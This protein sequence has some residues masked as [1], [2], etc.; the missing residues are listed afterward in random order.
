MNISE[1]MLC[2]EG[3]WT[4]VPNLPVFINEEE[5][6]AV[7]QA[8]ESRTTINKRVED[9]LEEISDA[10]D[11]N[12][13]VLR[14]LSSYSGTAGLEDFYENSDASD[15]SFPPWLYN[16]IFKVMM[17]M[18]ENPDSILFHNAG[19]GKAI[20]LLP[21]E[22]KERINKGLTKIAIVNEVE[23]TSTKI[24]RILYPGVPC[25]FKDENVVIRDS[26]QGIA[27]FN[28][29]IG[30]SYDVIISHSPSAVEI[31]E[32]SKALNEG[33]FLITMVEPDLTESVAHE[34]RR[35]IINKL[36]VIG[37][38]R[39]S[40]FS[41]IECSGLDYGYDIMVFR[42]P[43][44]VDR[45]FSTIVKNM[46][47]HYVSCIEDIKDDQL[48]KK[49]KTVEEICASGEM[50]KQ[51]CQLSQQ[52]EV[53]EVHMALYLK[54]I[55]IR[56]KM[57]ECWCQPHGMEMQVRT[58]YKKRSFDILLGIVKQQFREVMSKDGMVASDVNALLS[59]KT[60]NSRIYSNIVVRIND[61]LKNEAGDLK[62]TD[63]VKSKPIWLFTTNSYDGKPK[64]SGSYNIIFDLIREFDGHYDYSLLESTSELFVYKNKWFITHKYGHGDN[65]IYFKPSIGLYY[66]PIGKIDFLTEAHTFKTYLF[67][68]Q[69]QKEIT[70]KD[71]IVYLGN[72][73]VGIGSVIIHEGLILKKLSNDTK[74]L[75]SQAFDLAA[76]TYGIDVA[77]RVVQ[78]SMQY[79][80]ESIYQEA[81]NS[82]DDLSLGDAEN[83]LFGI[84]RFALKDASDKDVLSL[85]EMLQDV[86]YSG[87]SSRYL[88]V[89]DLA[90]NDNE[91]ELLIGRITFIDHLI[92][93]RNLINNNIDTEDN[94]ILLKQHYEAFCEQHQVARIAEDKIIIK[95]F[96]HPENENKSD[97]RWFIIRSFDKAYH[98]GRGLF[99][100]SLPY[101]LNEVV[102]TPLE[103]LN[104]VCSK[105]DYRV[106][107]D[108]KHLLK[109]GAKYNYTGRYPTAIIDFEDRKE[110]IRQCTETGEWVVDVDNIFRGEYLIKTEKFVFGNIG[111]KLSK[112]KEFETWC[113]SKNI[114]TDNISLDLIISELQNK[115][116]SIPTIPEQII[117]FDPHMHIVDFKKV[118]F[119]FIQAAYNGASIIE[120]DFKIDKTEN[121]GVGR[122]KYYGKQFDAEIPG[123]A[124]KS[125]PV[126]RNMLIRWFNHEPE[127][128]AERD[129]R[130]KVVNTKHGKAKMI[131]DVEL[132]S[133]RN[134]FLRAKFND[135][136]R[137][138]LDEKSRQELYDKYNE[139]Y[140]IYV[141]KFSEEKLGVKGM[142]TIFNGKP[143]AM[144][145]FQNRFAAR[146][147][148]M[149]R[150]YGNH[151]VGSGKTISALAAGWIAKQ[152]GLINKAMYV[153]LLKNLSQWEQH[154]KEL[155]PTATCLVVTNANK[156]MA[157]CDIAVNDYDFIII[158]DSTWSECI[159][160]SSQFK[161]DV[162]K[163]E[164][165][166]YFQVK[167][168]L[169]VL[170]AKNYES[171][172][173]IKPQL[174]S[175]TKYINKELNRIS[176]LLERSKND[177]IE[178][179]FDKMGVD[180]L[181]V[182]EADVYKNVDTGMDSYLQK[183][184][185]IRKVS[186]GIATTMRLASQFIQMQYNY[187]NR[188]DMTGT[189]VSNSATEIYQT[190]NSITPDLLKDAGILT[191][192]D[193]I[194]S[195]GRVEPKEVVNTQNQIETKPTFTGMRNVNQIKRLINACFDVLTQ[196]T[197]NDIKR[198]QGDPI[199]TA[200]YDNVIYPSTPE[201]ILMNHYSQ[202]QVTVMKELAKLPPESKAI[203]TRK[204]N[205]V[206]KQLKQLRS[207][208]EAKLKY[209]IDTNEIQAM[210]LEINELD[211]VRRLLS[212]NGGVLY[213]QIRS[214]IVHTKLYN[215]FIDDSWREHSKIKKVVERAVKSYLYNDFDE[216]INIDGLDFYVKD[217]K[218]RAVKNGQ[219][220]LLD[221]MSRSDID[222]FNARDEYIAAIKAALPDEDGVNKEKLFAS[223]D[224]TSSEPLDMRRVKKILLEYFDTPNKNYEQA[225]KYFEQYNGED[226]FFELTAVVDKKNKKPK[227]I[228]YRDIV[229]YLYNLGFIRFVFGSTDSMGIGMNLQR[230]TTN[231]H[232]ID[233]PFRPRDWEQRIGR[234]LRQGNYNSE[235]WIHSYSSEGGSEV[236][237]LQLLRIKE[238]F[239]QQIFDLKSL[240]D[241]TAE[242][243]I[244][245][246]MTG[247][248]E[249]QS[250]FLSQLDTM[251]HDTNDKRIQSF[252]DQ[253]KELESLLNRRIMYHAVIDNHIR[254]KARLQEQISTIE[255]NTEMYVWLSFDVLPEIEKKEAEQDRLDEEYAERVRAIKNSEEY[256]S[257]IKHIEERHQ[258]VIDLIT[259]PARKSRAVH[260]MEQKIY[261]LKASFIPEPPLVGDFDFE[262]KTSLPYRFDWARSFNNEIC[263]LLFDCYVSREVSGY[264]RG[265]Y[266]T[267][268]EQTFNYEL[269]EKK[270]FTP[271]IAKRL[272]RSRV[273]SFEKGDTYT[274]G[275]LS[276]IIRQKISLIGRV[277]DSEVMGCENFEK[278]IANVDYLET[279]KKAEY[280]LDAVNPDNLESLIN[281]KSKEVAENQDAY[282]DFIEKQEQI[283][284]FA[285]YTVEKL[286]GFDSIEQ[287]M[288]EISGFV[289]LKK[290]YESDA[291]GEL[292][293][294]SSYLDE[295]ILL[296]AEYI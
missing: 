179:S 244:T 266:V 14:V 126:R 28:K 169:E 206:K 282:Y 72:D 174:K 277:M 134:V 147:L 84:A 53:D 100:D 78:F 63:I 29:I 194:A 49:L 243:S 233:M 195:H 203:I 92:E 110:F 246:L 22:I 58:L 262:F 168:Y 190:L 119:P 293:T 77:N 129:K 144:N 230:T 208:V 199:P 143:F 156:K 26:N 47:A 98:K 27:G 33:G 165:E 35:G 107:V 148:K 219:L 283:S 44:R 150:L 123:W 205:E 265:K 160:L 48:V 286:A 45:V 61:H 105:S 91:Y 66:T 164:L 60:L 1:M 146:F 210:E 71:N 196:Q 25:Y 269:L 271:D 245:G 268:T 51:L 225:V 94:K 55:V 249:E 118:V 90:K 89:T 163:E 224:A 182:D 197:L 259:D 69:P 285:S 273:Y 292:P 216:I 248:V 220:F 11:V 128:M 138:V 279:I 276:R 81:R 75:V 103:Y 290:S 158:S 24:S 31:V 280:A 162:S 242:A 23:N 295:K 180:A 65:D 173:I 154:V 88:D 124:L 4:P 19:I 223:I 106:K 76:S 202:H 13:D 186:S 261:D 16:G 97:D 218:R 86:F 170:Y 151:A 153:V 296:V 7:P 191:F 251:I 59:S 142:A 222:N 252:V 188:I 192:N 73:N 38:M 214:G 68:Y 260:E 112:I 267:T 127:E 209:N 137:N 62:I 10:D 189:P 155:F 57:N 111:K 56:A 121:E 39:L 187:C 37:V 213:N 161:A 15:F 238:N 54:R 87:D 96:L 131:T 288:E 235:L 172:T 85:T 99:S 42:K 64:G 135:Y 52:A 20:G 232:H 207:A 258:V 239:I 116:L 80:L 274:L 264:K 43:E 281:K 145:S 287:R 228:N 104:M 201:K 198:E 152:E 193:F 221:R 178:M 34:P 132:T 50:Y 175:I 157:I 257:A 41:I 211:R 270:L 79:T 36:D 122:M 136:I 256:L 255:R 141:P 171:K 5:T 113:N 278:T 236:V 254:N 234:G 120:N 229:K 176:K 226:D 185:G 108:V 250:I 82:K 212:F 247:D 2:K 109:N 237:M 115:I 3:L 177:Y 133:E 167:E 275:Q 263:E 227:K 140:Q 93:I 181:I 17:E 231:E 253:R 184:K 215:E 159:D 289:Q 9:V 125:T 40:P 18:D 200:I 12:E 74:H 240:D 46:P 241:F 117:D 83:S 101:D 149:H 204:K 166:Q 183:V 291:I 114:D 272:G 102:F 6:K 284:R 139:C 130:G 30:R 32:L 294:P 95:Y 217:G 67:P 21:S 8:A 70:R